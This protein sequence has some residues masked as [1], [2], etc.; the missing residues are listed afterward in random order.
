MNLP[1][2]LTVMRMALIPVFLVFMLAESIPHRYLIAAVIFAA[3]SFTDYLDGHIARRDGL[4]TNF[5]KLMDPLADKLLVFSALVCFIELEMSSALIVFIILAR[6]FLVTSVRLI[7]AE[8]GTVIAADIWGKM[9]TVSQIIWVLVALIA[10]WLE[11]SWPLFMTVSPGASAPPAPVIFL[12]GLS[13]V[14]QTIVVI[15]TVFSGFNYI[16][17]NRSLLGDIK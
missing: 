12:I 7:A 15:L 14:I 3:A 9:K 11:E 5:G 10:L 6:E 13:F 8:Q 2:K 16:W 1:N 17:K 4:V